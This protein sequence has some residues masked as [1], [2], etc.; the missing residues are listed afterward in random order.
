MQATSSSTEHVSSRPS[1][2]L[3]F[4]FS[5]LRGF[6]ESTKQGIEIDRKGDYGKGVRYIATTVLFL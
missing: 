3:A 6:L 2:G 5:S 4:V 1:G